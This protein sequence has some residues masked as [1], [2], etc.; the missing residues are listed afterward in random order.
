MTSPAALRE[1]A[2]GLEAAAARKQQLADELRREADLLP[3]GSD[4]LVGAITPD[5]WEGRAAEAAADA[6]ATSAQ[7][8]RMAAED[9]ERVAAELEAEAA[10][11]RQEAA[12]LG[13]QADELQAQ[14]DAE[15]AALTG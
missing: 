4:R 11:L 8:V 2:S 5:I 7:V 10:D 3:D 9:V 14:L 15:A 6:L 12:A 13:L 1:E